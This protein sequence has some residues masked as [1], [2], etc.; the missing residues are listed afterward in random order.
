MLIERGKGKAITYS[1]A[2]LITSFSFTVLSPALTS[3]T[4]SRR[5]YDLL[6]SGQGDSIPIQIDGTCNGLQHLSAMFRDSEAAQHVNLIDGLTPA[7]IYG[8]VAE[9]VLEKLEPLKDTEAWVQRICHLKIDRGLCKQPVM[10]LPYG[11]TR[12]GIED[13]IIKKGAEREPTPSYWRECLK[14]TLEGWRPDEEAIEGG[15]MA[16]ADRD[17]DKHPLFKMDCRKLALVMWEAIEETVPKPLHAMQAFKRLAKAAGDG[18]LC[19]GLGPEVDGLVIK[20]AR[21]K[22]SMRRMRF[23]GLHLPDGIKT[24]QMLVG[25]GEVDRGYHSMGIVANFIHSHDAD[26]LCRTMGCF[27]EM[28]GGAFGAVH[29]CFMAR[30]SEIDLLHKAVRRT[31]A[32][33]Y[34][35]DRDPIGADRSPHPLNQPVT[36]C[37]AKTG[38]MEQGWTSIWKMAEE[39]H[40]SLP[41]MGDFDMSEVLNSRWFFS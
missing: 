41:E 38:K 12:P 34:G 25:R 1:L 30:P 5:T 40:V 23:K 19:W 14:W 13:M 27:K 8:V 2:T 3:H 6:L 10:T 11:A 33:K 18:V 36:I 20:Q 32:F 17:L 7:D 31:F 9:R 16:F 39:L 22:A 35:W 4:S 24:L 26:H 28:G 21:N 29:D 37:N 15:Y